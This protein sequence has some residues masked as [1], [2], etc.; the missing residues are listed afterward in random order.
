MTLPYAEPYKN[1]DVRGHPHSTREE[2]EVWIREACHNLQR[3]DETIDLLTDCTGGTF[4]L[5]PLSLII[6]N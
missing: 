1:Q 5:E 2:R 4:D 3:R 6:R